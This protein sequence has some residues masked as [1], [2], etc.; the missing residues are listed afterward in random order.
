MFKYVVYRSLLTTV[1]V[2]CKV[3]AA[4]V[5]RCK[6]AAEKYN[7]KAKP[8]W[9]RK[10]KELLNRREEC[11]TMERSFFCG[12]DKAPKILELEAVP[13][14]AARMLDGLFLKHY[15]SE[16]LCLLFGCMEDAALEVQDGYA[17][18]VANALGDI[19]W[20]Y[21]A[22]THLYLRKRYGRGAPLPLLSMASADAMWEVCMSYFYRVQ[23]STVSLLGMG[24]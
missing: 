18:S 7:Q 19:N 15:K 16:E 22:R 14:V 24:S 1:R 21:E 8:V 6:E 17:L 10:D 4:T 20:R 23:I 9:E 12:L 2:F 3:D 11:N 13:E 5:R